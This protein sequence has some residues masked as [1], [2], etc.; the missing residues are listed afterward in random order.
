MRL[1]TSHLW[2]A[3]SIIGLFIHFR[4]GIV[5]VLATIVILSQDAE[6]HKLKVGGKADE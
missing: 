5:L 3:T 6:L 1:N 4:M 2:I